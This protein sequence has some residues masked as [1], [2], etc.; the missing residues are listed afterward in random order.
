MYENKTLL[1]QQD[2]SMGIVAEFSA[3]SG[4]KYPLTAQ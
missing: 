1:W 2:L 4:R 3:W